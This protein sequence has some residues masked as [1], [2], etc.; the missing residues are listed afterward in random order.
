M[1]H[2]SLILIFIS[3]L[4]FAAEFREGTLFLEINLATDQRIEISANTTYIS[5]ESGLFGQELHGNLAFESLP[6]AVESRFGILDWVQEAGPESPPDG[7]LSKS[8]A[9]EEDHL[10][11]KQE[12]HYFL[13]QSFSDKDRALDFAHVLGINPKN[14]H[15]IP[16]VNPRIKVIDASGEEF[17]FESP[18][19]IISDQLWLRDRVY[20]SE[21]VLKVINGKLVLNHVVP[22]EEYIAGVIPNEI[23]NDCPMEA[24]KAQAVAARSHAVSLLLYNRHQNDGYDLCNSTHCQV[25]KGKYLR[26]DEINQAVSA[27]ALEIMTVEDRVA[28]ATY[29]SSCGGKTD[30]SHAIWN[31]KDI[32]H[33]SGSI[34]IPEAKNFDLTSESGAARWIDSPLDT[35]GMSSWERGSL[36]WQKNISSSELAKNLGVSSI[37]SIRIVK[38]GK[39]G[40]ITSMLI[41]NTHRIDGE[42]RVRQAFGMLPS[43]FFY[44]A[45]QAG[46]N[47]I[48]PGKMITLKGRGSGHGVGMCQVGALRMSRNGKNYTEILQTYYPNIRL[49]TQWIP[50]EY[51]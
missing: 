5:D 27:T 4:L 9:W 21:F 42:Y 41:N 20:D 46:K 29:H 45:G 10:V 26:N 43:S 17:Y 37:R 2:I 13:E 8:F 49:S 25:Y 35:S 39:S 18:I 1:K 31:G 15:E 38:R 44:F 47:I 30:S 14:V 12:M 7:V 50:D 19:R 40:R 3:S 36:N 51:K 22:L 6:G 48:Y 11:L 32:P 33:L 28:D 24:L 23:G 16:I 34:C